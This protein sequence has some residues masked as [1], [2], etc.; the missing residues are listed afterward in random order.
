LQLDKLGTASGFRRE[1]DAEHRGE[2]AVPIPEPR[3]LLLY[4]AVRRIADR[5][6]V[7]LEEAKAA[8]DR[9]FREYVLVLFDSGGAGVD[10]WEYV[11]IDWEQM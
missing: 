9:A 5:C 3:L 7:S 4:E 8:L 1:P 10:D 2:G 11:T 6:G